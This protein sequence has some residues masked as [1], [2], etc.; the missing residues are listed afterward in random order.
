VVIFLG[1]GIFGGQ[2]KDIDN[3]DNKDNKAAATKK[4]RRK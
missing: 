4:S 1:A 3:K 2:L